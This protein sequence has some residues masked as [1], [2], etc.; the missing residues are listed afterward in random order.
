MLSAF[1]RAAAS[2]SHREDGLTIPIVALTLVLLMVFAAFVLDFGLVY[3]ER[4]NDQNA[5]D[6]AATSGAVQFLRTQSKQGAVDEILAKVDVDLGRAVAASAWVTCDDPGSLS[7]TAVTLGLTPATDCISFSAGYNRIRVRIPDQTVSTSFGRVVGINSFTSS[8]LA[9]VGTTPA[10]GGALPFVVT[11]LSGAGDQICLRTDGTGGS[12]PP[13]QPPPSGDPYGQGYQLDPCNKDNFD[14]YQGARGTIKPYFYNGC[15]KPTGNQS[16]VDAIMV[17][18]DHQLGVFEPEV[19]LAPG[20]SANALDLNP[21]ARFDGANSCGV[22]F[23]NT[24]DVD[25]GLTAGVLTCALLMSPCPDGSSATA[26]LPG[27][28]SGSSSVASFAELGINDQPL[29]D[30]FVSS[31]PL[32]APP[33]CADAKS[34]ATEF[35]RRRAALQDCLAKW[36]TGVLFVDAIAEQKR[37]GFIPRIAERAICDTQP[38]PPSDPDCQGGN[39]P[40]DN[41]HLN[42]FS[43]VYID[44]LYQSTSG[45]CDTLNPATPAGST[46][47]SIHYP[48]KGMKC[49]NGPGTDKVDRVSGLLLPCG[50]LPAT[51]CDA[52]SNPPFPDPIGLARIRLVK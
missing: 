44:A 36:T 49:G 8:A 11:A 46:T 19:S 17:G 42:N 14:T 12:E 25:T 51:V 7:H 24:V 27:R 18:M 41:V 50:A 33:S 22:A 9:E 28:L 10:G 15:N 43:P 20:E 26:G 38:N 32:G 6:A 1:G 45:I 30:Y 40:L 37:L 2:R 29:W 34:D 21:G 48:G 3:S 47:W 52:S 16:V 5:A 35:Y 13:E 4:R 23:P 39:G 31:L